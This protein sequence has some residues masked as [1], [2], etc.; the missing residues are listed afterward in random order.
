VNGRPDIRI[1]VSLCVTVA[2]AILL[3]VSLAT[4][5]TRTVV[6]QTVAPPRASIAHRVGAYAVKPADLPLFAATGLTLA[7]T[8]NPGVTPPAGVAYDDARVV[9]TWRDPI[10]AYHCRALATTC[11]VPA[12]VQAGILAREETILTEDA[13][14]PHVAAV[15][16]LDDYVGN[17]AGLLEDI[18]TIA[19]ADGLPVVCGFG[20]TLDY[21]KGAGY[22]HAYTSL[23]HFTAR[24]LLNVGGC[25]YAQ[26]YLYAFGNLTA[27]SD[28]QMTWLLPAMR[29]DLRA[30]GF[31]GAL[32]GA[33]QAWGANPPTGAQLAEQTAAFC[34]AGA[35]SV[36]AFTWH[37]FPTTTPELADSAGLRKGLADGLQKCKAIWGTRVSPRGPGSN[38][39]A[40]AAG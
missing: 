30:A 6:Q 19:R 1:V 18:H 16:A 14:N 38:G 5:T 17:V 20:A 28:F 12:S 24:E 36:V 23:Q 27:T 15:Y 29:A 34:E 13:H 3:V 32:I 2:L 21:D 40:R 7:Q 4:R 9:G 25:D 11:P 8:L 26:L 10:L 33:P 35:V 37:N 31:T 22:E 39:R